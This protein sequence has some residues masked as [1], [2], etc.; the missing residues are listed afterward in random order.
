MLVQNKFLVLYS[1][2]GLLFA[3][4]NVA[5]TIQLERSPTVTLSSLTQYVYK[6]HPSL[7]TEQAQQQQIDANTALA[8]TPFA[9]VSSVSVNHQNDVIGSHD[10]LQEWEA[11]VGM[12]L[13]LPGQKQQQLLLSD[14][15]SA[16]LPAYKQQ[17]RL[18]ASAT[19]RE[20]IWHAVLAETADKQALQAWNT[21]QN[22]EQDVDSKVA[23]GELAAAESLLASSHT[24]ELYS[25]YLLTQA[26]LAHAL[27]QY[28]HRTGEQALPQDYEEVLSIQ[29]DRLQHHSSAIIDPQHPDLKVLD[30]HI[31]T[32]HT[33]QDLARFEGAVNPELSLGIRRERGSDDENYNNSVG[34]GISFALGN[35]VYRRPAIALAAKELADAEVTRQQVEHELNAVLFSQL[36]D[37]A[38]KQQQLD[39]ENQRVETSRQYFS[40]QQRAFELGE[41]DLVSVLH[42]QSI[43]NKAQNRK[44][45]LQ[46]EM[47]QLIAQIN[48][49]RGVAL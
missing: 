28:H 35:D 33:K 49:A 13:W 30:Q 15:L 31:A 36:H 48:Q 39:L 18:Q 42:S 10:G 4:I 46:I 34:I 11:S 45:R 20:L 40:L 41:I 32:L 7:H 1:M 37:L 43:A 16:E 19:I 5:E 29:Q 23:A 26:A 22:L 38:S 21:A 2:L 6:H 12:P 3:D 47:K 27:K 17:I 8:T 25:Q 44:L 9:N 14:K 24:L